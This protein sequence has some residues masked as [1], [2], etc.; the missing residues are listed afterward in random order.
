[1]SDPVAGA[2][3]YA[4]VRV[5]EI[6][7]ESVRPFAEVEAEVRRELAVQRAV[8]AVSDLH[9]KVEDMRASARPLAEIA[10]EL[11]LPAVTFG[12][13][14]R[15]RQTETGQPLPPVPAVEQLVEAMFRS[16]MGSDNEAVRT[17]D[18]G[19][20]WYE[21][22]AIDPA[23]DREL[24]DVRDTVEALWR[25]DEIA[26]RLQAKAREAV[27]RVG[28][29][30]TIEA[31]A[32]SL[33]ASVTTSPP[34][35]RT[36]SDPAYPPAALVAAFGTRVGGA[37]SAA[38]PGD[39]GRIVF[40]VTSAAIPPFLRTAQQ[41]EQAA[42]ELSLALGDDI[43]VQY[44]AALQARQGVRINQQNLRNATGGGDS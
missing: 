17:R 41:A 38:M 8:R 25:Q 40:V 9:D 43:L 24:A 44:V 13:V 7:P 26:S 4:L 15:Q 37:G 2:L 34:L 31:V 18:N 19:Y 33:G 36:A 11:K 23:R 28:K 5:T 20:V 21:L 27:E 1:V 3:G 22:T 10:A 12:P 29:G 35:T 30:E 39:A 32:A 6:A 14:D 16:E 42:Q